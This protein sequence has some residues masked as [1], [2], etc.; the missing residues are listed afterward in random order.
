ML[1]VLFVLVTVTSALAA[2]A[3][4]LA[5]RLVMLDTRRLAGDERPEEVEPILNKP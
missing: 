1:D 5:A 4:G 2:L 3:V